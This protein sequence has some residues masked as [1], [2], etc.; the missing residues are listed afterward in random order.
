MARAESAQLHTPGS[1]PGTEDIGK[2][3]EFALCDG[4]ARFFRKRLRRIDQ[5]DMGESLGKIPQ[6]PLALWI[7]FLREQA[8]IIPQIEET[9]E[10]DACVFFPSRKMKAIREPK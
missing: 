3:R 7:V 4:G 6:L 5:A 9:L 2:L 1:H 8:D 10:Q